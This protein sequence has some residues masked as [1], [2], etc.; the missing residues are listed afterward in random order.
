MVRSEREFFQSIAPNRAIRY[1]L[2]TE[3]GDV[4]SFT[5]QLEFWDGDAWRPVVRFDSA[6]GRPHRDLLDW[7]GRV[8]AKTW[9]PEEITKSE[10]VTL[11]RTDLMDHADA[12]IDA[13]LE[14][15]HE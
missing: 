13:F 6:H 3:R 11:A 9:L 14:L 7:Q 12:Y 1:R 15:R 2:V 4:R 10:A 8:N 5:V